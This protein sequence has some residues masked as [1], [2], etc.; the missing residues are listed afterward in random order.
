MKSEIIYLVSNAIISIYGVLVKYYKTVPLFEQLFLRT[1]AFVIIAFTALSGKGINFETIIME[2]VLS[3]R[4]ILLSTV[5]LAS[6]YGIYISFQELGIGV[7]NSLFL[8]WPI[9]LYL[10][11]IPILNSSFSEKE[12]IILLLT[13]LAT[14]LTLY[15]KIN[16][17][18]NNRTTVD[19]MIGLFGLIIS[20]ATHIFTI[21]YF[22]KETPDIN[23]YLLQ[24]YGFGLVLFIVLYFSDG[25]SL[26]PCKEYFPIFFY[27]IIFG[28]LGFYINFYSIERLKPF[29][30]SI[31]AFLSIAISFLMGYGFFGESSNIYQWIGII[32]IVLANY[33]S[34]TRIDISDKSST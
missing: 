6:I 16:G 15:K 34:Y 11:A 7:T 4:A 2:N 23:K 17:D 25:F 21:V 10:V 1:L 19:L 5:N 8:T 3:Y 12:F 33:Y 18:L 27:T 13:T 31:L 30:I 32:I 24:L 14:T 20:V 29:K 9:L 22:K 28:Y 26:A